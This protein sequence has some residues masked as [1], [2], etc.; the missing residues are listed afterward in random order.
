MNGTTAP[1]KEAE[2]AFYYKKIQV[3]IKYRRPLD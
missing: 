1:M 2:R 3:K